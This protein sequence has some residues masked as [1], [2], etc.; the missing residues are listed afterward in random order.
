MLQEDAE[1]ERRSYY[2]KCGINLVK[3]K[4]LNRKIYS[5]LEERRNVIEAKKGIV[6]KLQ[7]NY[8][9]LLY[10]QAYLQREIRA[11][12][13]L[14]TPNLTEI[15]QE[16]GRALGTSV[17][18][19]DLVEINSKAIAALKAEQSARLETEETLTKLKDTRN[20]ALKKLD[21]KRKFV[22]ELPAKIE[23]ISAAANAISA[24][25]VDIQK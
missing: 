14:A 8:E 17:F 15:E 18:S 24:Q 21:R 11:C 1:D 9:N 12:K 3:V 6:D 13:D 7:L 20:E 2:K 25:F 19:E 23:S 5:E 4:A 10:K 16:L 22:D